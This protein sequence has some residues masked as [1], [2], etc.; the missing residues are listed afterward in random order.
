MN[1]NALPACTADA[2]E[3]RYLAHSDPWQFATSTYEQ[4]RYS[5]TMKA[6]RQARFRRAFEPGC[7][8]GLL[9]A[10]LA[11]RCETLLA[12]DVSATALAGARR[13]CASFPN[14]Q[15]AVADV[16]QSLPEGPFDLI[17]FSEIGYYFRVSQLEVMGARLAGLLEPGGQ[18][19]A[20]HWLGASEDHV[21]HGNEVHEALLATLPLSH[22]ESARHSG[23]R[24][25]SWIRV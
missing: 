22:T 7:S 4:N 10:R 5:V 23:F 17:V 24:L 11:E 20:V 14:V 18:L 13:R 12:S 15:F 1:L 16:S 2:F 8:I 19:L 3:R 25:D 21:L 9:T 6:L